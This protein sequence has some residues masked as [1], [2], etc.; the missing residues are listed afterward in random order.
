M[1]LRT[2]VLAGIS[3]G[4][5]AVGIALW[6]SP[7]VATATGVES[8][9]ARVDNAYIL[10]FAA[11]CIALLLAFTLAMTRVLA[12]TETVSM[13][14]VETVAATETPGEEFDTALAELAG[15]RG[16]AARARS[17]RDRIERRLRT[18]AVRT[19]ARVDGCSSDTARGRVADGAWTDDRYAAAFVGDDVAGPR[20]WHRLRDRL[21]RVDPFERSARRTARAIVE[22]DGHDAVSTLTRDGGDRS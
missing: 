6:M 16:R 19:V 5:I 14:T 4:T 18:D 13:P 20:W 11:G 7:A 3:L 21:L 8:L 15:R 12:G 10:L 17:D 22:Y 1:T 2:R 9:L